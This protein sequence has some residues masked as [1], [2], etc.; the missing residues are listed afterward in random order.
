MS[1][2]ISIASFNTNTSNYKASHSRAVS[3]I[4][5]D[6]VVWWSSSNYSAAFILHAATCVSV[7]TLIDSTVLE[8]LF[9]HPPFWNVPF[10]FTKQGLR[11]LVSEV[12]MTYIPE[13]GYWLRCDFYHVFLASRHT[14]LAWRSNRMS[15][16]SKNHHG[17][18][19][20]IPRCTGQ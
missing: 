11:S 17:D 16:T 18:G 19:V 4:V 8:F 20:W 2:T 5:L 13:L 1:C 10:P 14:P 7:S 3:L 9:I 12:L 15:S 6:V